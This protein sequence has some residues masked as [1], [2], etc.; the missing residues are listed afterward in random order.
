MP[1]SEMPKLNSKPAYYHGHPR[2]GFRG[3]QPAEIIGVRMVE[4]KYGYRACF[5]S[6]YSDGFID[7]NPIED[8]KSYN[9]KVN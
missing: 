8:V 7:Y 4:T 3:D 9:I 1:E 5:M 2:Y 6:L